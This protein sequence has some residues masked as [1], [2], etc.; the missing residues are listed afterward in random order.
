VFR[1]VCGRRR[2]PL[3]RWAVR[4][5]W[6]VVPVA[7]IGEA[8]HHLLEALGRTVAHHLFHIAFAGLAAAAFIVYVAV[9]VGRHGWPTF[10]WRISPAGSKHP[11][12]T[13]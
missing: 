6:L 11:S 9:D 5:A 2:Q 8:G 13:P 3:R 1:E 7:L 4:L 10:S 12:P